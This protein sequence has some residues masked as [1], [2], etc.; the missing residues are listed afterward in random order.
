MGRAAR[1]VADFFRLAF[2]PLCASVLVVLLLQPIYYVSLATVGSIVPQQRIAAHLGAAFDSGVLSDD[3]NP[4]SLIFKGG[5]QFTECI[6]LGIGLNKAETA[7]Q[8]AVTGS[9]PMSGSTH[10]CHGLHQAVSGSET[11]WQPYFRYWHGYRLILAPL[12]AAFPLWIVKL[13]NALMIV[14]ACGVFWMTLRNY[15]GLAVATIFLMTFV[16][17]SDVLFVWRTST[18]CISLAYILVGTSLFAAALRKDWQAHNLIVMAAILGSVFNFIDFLVNPPMMPMLIAFFVLLANRRDA[19]MLALATVIAWFAGYA[20]TW[21]AKW[22]LAYLAM[23]SSAGVVSDILSTIE[24]RTVGALNGVYLVPLAATLRA[25]LRA[26]NRVGV[27]V[28]L[29]ILL[30]FAHYAATVSRIDWRRAL[31]LCSPALV[32]LLWFEVLSSH[33]QFHLTVSSRSAAM[34]FAIFLSAMVMSMPRRPSLPELWA[35]LQTLRAKLPLWRSKR[36]GP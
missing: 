14:A 20:E 9:Y 25:Y 5:E 24:V 26:L 36:A 4:R 19:G 18:H 16:C 23:P 12:A 34:A 35:Q 2:W 8:T 21:V 11:S 10:A 28:P 17:L 1:L 33:T 15:C 27:I 29:L 6:S 31:W 13:I 7:W 3:G 32:S 22:L 30:A